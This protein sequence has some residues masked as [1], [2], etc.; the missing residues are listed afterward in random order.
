MR[1]A[2][3]TASGRSQASRRSPRTRRPGRIVKVSTDLVHWTTEHVSY[4]TAFGW[5]DF[6][7]TPFTAGG[8]N[9]EVWVPVNRRRQ[10][11]FKIEGCGE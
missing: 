7:S 1:S 10:A 2:G 4:P 5:S 11:F 6:E 8:K 3:L 9:T